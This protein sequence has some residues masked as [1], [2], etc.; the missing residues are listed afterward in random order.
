MAMTI[1]V[2]ASLTAVLGAD[3]DSGGVIGWK[4]DDRFIGSNY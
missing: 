4:I 2:E 3:I 1:G